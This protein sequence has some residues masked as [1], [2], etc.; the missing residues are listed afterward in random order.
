MFKLITWCVVRGT[1]WSK[2]TYNLVCCADVLPTAYWFPSLFF[3]CRALQINA[4]ENGQGFAKIVS[5]SKLA[6]L[7]GD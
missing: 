1:S 5:N 6:S 7:F 3:F 4:L 2:M